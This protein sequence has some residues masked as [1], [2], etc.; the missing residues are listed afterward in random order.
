MTRSDGSSLADMPSAE[1]VPRGSDLGSDDGGWEENALY[2]SEGAQQ[3]AWE[4]IW[5][6]LVNAN[7]AIY[8]QELQDDAE[9]CGA[10]MPT[11]ITDPAVLAA[12]QDRAAV[13]PRSRSSGAASRR[14]LHSSPC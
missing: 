8:L 12:I 9:A 13:G 6:T 10:P 4:R 2:R 11:Q 1:E 14:R 3:D 7:T 5:Q